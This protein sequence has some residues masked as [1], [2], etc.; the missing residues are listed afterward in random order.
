M[1]SDDRCSLLRRL[2]IIVYDGIIVTAILLFAA[3]PPTVAMVSLADTVQEDSLLFRLALGAYLLLAGFAFFGGFWTHG[4]Q[5]IGMR[6]W[7]VRTV[8]R[9]GGPL[10]WRDAAVRYV[11]AVLS[12]LVLGIGFLWSLFDRDRLAWHDRIS[13]T[14]LRRVPRP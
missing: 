12:W 6:A 10:R 7:R 8:R 4:G 5:T 2:T 14:E 1:P 13:R 11:A 9:D 3:V